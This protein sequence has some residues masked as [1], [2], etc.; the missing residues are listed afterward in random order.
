MTCHG[1]GDAECTMWEG[2]GTG[3]GESGGG[4]PAG[5]GGGDPA[6]TGT[7]AGTGTGTAGPSCYVVGCEQCDSA[8]SNKCIQCFPD[9]TLD[10]ASYPSVCHAPMPP[11]GGSEAGT[12]TGT[13]GCMTDA[14][15]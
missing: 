8:D 10:T 1:E 3:T 6:G 11:A 14:D 2:A 15:C 7:E 9:H 4:D 12:G 13:G 5:T